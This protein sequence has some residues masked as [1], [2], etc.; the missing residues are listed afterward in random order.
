[1]YAI[2]LVQSP[3]ILVLRK[4]RDLIV[5]E[6]GRFSRSELRSSRSKIYDVHGLFG[7]TN[8]GNKYMMTLY[9]LFLSIES[10][11]CLVKVLCNNRSLMYLLYVL[12]IHYACSTLTC[13]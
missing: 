11:P 10:M 4:H 8:D 13:R 2:C 6:K 3:Y 5:W 9:A 12:Q 1:M 7:I